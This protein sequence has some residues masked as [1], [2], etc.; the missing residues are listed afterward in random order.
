MGPVEKMLSDKGNWTQGKLCRSKQ[1]GKIPPGL[2]PN[3]NCYCLLGAIRLH[4][5]ENSEVEDR[6]HKYLIETKSMY[7][8]LAELND[9]G[10][11]NLVMKIVR[12][13]GI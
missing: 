13:F 8:N 5:G 9:E 11:Y 10:G 6:L 3:E 7:K 2:D 12:E 4:Y 1:G